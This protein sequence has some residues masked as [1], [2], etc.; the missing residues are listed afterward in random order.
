[1]MQESKWFL[2]L[3]LVLAALAC[4]SGCSS[5]GHSGYTMESPYRHG[6]STVAVPIWQRGSKEFRRDIEIQ[7]T[8][9][10]VK[11]IQAETPYRIVDR[12]KADTILEGTLVSI[13]QHVLSFDPNNAQAREIEIT[14][15]VDFTWKDLR[16]GRIL[17]EKKKFR[18]SA[19]YIP[20][21]PFSEDFFLGNQ[22]V[23]NRI[24]LRIVEQM[25]EPW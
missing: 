13:T 22:D 2:T 12:T 25:Q 14:M 1:M 17:A 15:T 24:A 9:A 10:L 11:T 3:S 23:L 19:T 18:A 6:V 7:L 16:T 8:E 5:D 20:L 21:E 4:P